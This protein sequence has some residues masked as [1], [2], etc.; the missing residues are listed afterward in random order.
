VY[1]R[2]T[3]RLGTA[4]NESAAAGTSAAQQSTAPD[5]VAVTR[6]ELQDIKEQLDSVKL[7]VD[8]L[9]RHDVFKEQEYRVITHTGINNSFRAFFVLPFLGFSSS[10]DVATFLPVSSGRLRTLIFLLILI[11]F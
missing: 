3:G 7:R 8:R 11:G 9:S 10:V 5:P 4:N 1:L 2:R 6:T